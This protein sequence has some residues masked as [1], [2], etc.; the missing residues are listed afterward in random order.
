MASKPNGSINTS[1]VPVTSS[2]GNIKNATDVTLKQTNGDSNPA[3]PDEK[4]P[5]E[6]FESPEKH[7]PTE[8]FKSGEQGSI[9]VKAEPEKSNKKAQPIAGDKRDYEL[10]SAQG[11]PD[12]PSVD[13]ST[14]PAK[15]R[16]RTTKK[17]I[18]DEH[19]T[20]SATNG[21][22]KDASRAKK[23][24]EALQKATPSDGI[25]SRTRSRTKASS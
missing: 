9:A 6:V 11:D 1:P 23:V 5:A 17:Q 3:K 25:G 22:T 18:Q 24:K 21:E 2:D 14:K 19:A 12:K 10:A 13:N 7:K 8:G 4:Q 20:A 16:Q 15:K